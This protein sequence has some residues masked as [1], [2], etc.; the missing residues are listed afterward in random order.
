MIHDSAVTSYRNPA[1]APWALDS[2]LAAGLASRSLLGHSHTEY[3]ELGHT[4][5]LSDISNGGE[6]LDRILCDQDF[7]AIFLQ[8]G[9]IAWQ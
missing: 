1:R 7:N 3:S 2:E 9:S 8:D 4:H 6:V 5:E